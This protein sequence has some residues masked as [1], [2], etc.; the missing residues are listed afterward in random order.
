M[1]IKVVLV[2]G[3]LLVLA[4]AV[5]FMTMTGNV[6][7]NHEGLVECNIA[8]FNGDGVINYNDRLEFGKIY[9]SDYA[10]RKSC[11]RADL[12]EDNIINHLDNDEFGRVYNLYEETNTGECI[13]KKLA[14]EEP[15]IIAKDE[16]TKR[17]VP[18]PFGELSTQKIGFFQKTKDF[19]KELFGN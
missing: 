4:F 12:N 16:E 7:N 18:T 3:L 15:E 11:S 10:S 1:R 5:G 14:C 6:I 2:I 19:F 13:L 17:E 8:D 9:A